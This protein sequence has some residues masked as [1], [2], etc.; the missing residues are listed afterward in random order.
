MTFQRP[1]V[2]S[3][4]IPTI[5][6]A[7]PFGNVIHSEYIGG[8]PNVTYKVVVPE[9]VFAVR[10]SNHGYTSFEHLE[11]EVAL[12]QHLTN[13]GFQESPR[14]IAGSNGE[15]LQRWN[16]YW[17]RAAKFI[18]GDTGDTV[19]I[20]SVLCRDVGKVVASLQRA[21]DLF[22]PG[23][24]LEHETFIERAEN[25][26]SE[27]PAILSERGWALDTDT[28]VPQWKRS[29]EEFMRYANELKTNIIHADIWPPNVICERGAIIGLIDFDDWCHGASIIDLCAALSEFPAFMT[30]TMNEGFALALIQGY[31]SNGGTITELE[32]HLIAD[33]IE[34]V[35]A[36]WF[37]CNVIQNPNFSE[38]EIYLRKLESLKD[39]ASKENLRA[40]FHRLVKMARKQL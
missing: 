37:A 31:L 23:R 17:V 19:E 38:S 39:D 10:V 22:N 4:D 13:L 15:I 16:D 9:G 36:T 29:S 5:M 27:F 30:V 12:L 40:D 32:E 28:V 35:F 8:V 2:N 6:K 1:I 21:L 18:P 11:L 34:M 24:I 20:N 7:Y 14:L 33:G 25:L 26:F 3:Q